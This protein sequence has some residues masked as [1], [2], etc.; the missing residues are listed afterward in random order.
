MAPRAPLIFEHRSMPLL[1]RR[2]FIRRQI[3]HALIA[4]LL[5]AASLAIGAVGY[6]AFE[7]LS[8]ID[9]FYSAAMILTGMGPAFECKTDAAKIFASI[10]AIFSGV[11]FLTAASVLVAPALHRF[12]HRLHMDEDAGESGTDG[13]QRQSRR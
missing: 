12:L 9:S 10:Y 3:M 2:E 1:P 6:K 11:V 7:G 13:D 5:I 8:W 4:T